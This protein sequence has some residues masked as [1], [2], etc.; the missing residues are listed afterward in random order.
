MIK[1]G[2]VSNVTDDSNTY[3]RS[4]AAFNDKITDFLRVSPYGVESNPPLSSW[5]LL[6]SSQGQESV[7]VGMAADFLNRIKGLKAGE[8]RLH[9]TLTG[10]NLLLKENG[11]IEVDSQNDLNITVAGNTTITNTGN[12]IANVTGNMTSTVLGNMVSTVTGTTTITSNIITA[13]ATVSANI[14]APAINLTGTVNIVGTLEVSG[15]AKINGD[16]SACGKIQDCDAPPT[17]YHP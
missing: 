2:S 14:T 7:K 15:T 11:D 1:Q 5:V 6:L 13:T 3:P 8:V 16:L 9:N 10:S 4:Q 12:L 17:V